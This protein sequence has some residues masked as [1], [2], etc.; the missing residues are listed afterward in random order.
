MFRNLTQCCSNLVYTRLNLLY[1]QVMSRLYYF[2][3]N[4]KTDKLVTVDFR[5]N[6]GVTELI[7][8]NFVNYDMNFVKPKQHQMTC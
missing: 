2:F 8:Y 6:L 1:Y 7:S 4:N 5:S 3:L